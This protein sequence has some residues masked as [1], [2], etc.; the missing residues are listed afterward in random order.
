V[1]PLLL[2]LLFGLFIIPHSGFAQRRLEGIVYDAFNKQ[3]VGE[4]LIRN[5]N[6]NQKSYNDSRGEFDILVSPGDQLIIRKTGYISDTIE[7]KEQPALIIYLKEAVKQIQEIRVVGRRNPDDVLEEMKRDYKKA[8]DLAAPREAL[9]VGPS[10]AGLSID[11][12]YSKISKEAKNARRFTTHIGQLHEQNVVEYIFTP[13][14]VH[15]LIGLEGEDLQVFMKIFKP[16]YEQISTM[17]KEELGI[18]VKKMYEVYKLHPNLRPLRELPD[19]KM[20]VKKEN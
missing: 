12:L 3:R 15:N 11:Y 9:S 7:I 10:G 14:F 2:F 1:K 18:H 4:V 20:D 19:I 5:V 16:S 6:T 13:D 17:S 8:F